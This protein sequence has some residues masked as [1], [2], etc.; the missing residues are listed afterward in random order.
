[1]SKN[2]IENMLKNAGLS[3]IKTEHNN[4]A[5]KNILTL[6]VMQKRP[7]QKNIIKTVFAV[8]FSLGFII[9]TAGILAI[10]SSNTAIQQTTNSISIAAVDIHDVNMHTGPDQIADDLGTLWC[11]CSDTKENG[12]SDVWPPPSTLVQNNFIKSSPGYGEKG[13]AIRFK[14]RAGKKDKTGTIG[15]SALLGPPCRGPD[16]TGVNIKSYK[17]IRFKIKGNLTGGKLVLLIARGDSSVPPQVSACITPSTPIAVEANLT[18][19]VGPK[20]RTV[21]LNLRNDFN[22]KANGDRT[23]ETNPDNVLANARLVKWYVR[24]G[25]GDKVDIWIDELEFL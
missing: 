19:Y 8:G 17:K 16:C 13:Y 15:V 2:S 24:D 3:D 20:W 18:N 11:T 1:M 10:K 25:R 21:T 4:K 22:M 23:K 6:A 12:I 9:G 7:K 14:G 5:I